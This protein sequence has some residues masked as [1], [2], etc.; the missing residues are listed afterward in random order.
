MRKNGGLS[1]RL[2][3]LAITMVA[4]LLWPLCVPAADPGGG[5]TVGDL[6]PGSE[7]TVPEEEVKD[8]FFGY[9]IGL[10]IADAY[11]SLAA[12]D[13]AHVLGEFAGK[14]SV[15][16]ELIDGV[17]RLKGESGDP[18]LISIFFLERLKTPVPYSI[19][20]YHPGSVVAD[21]TVRFY[22]YYVPR[23]SVWLS[24]QSRVTLTEVHIFAI[25]DG[26]VVVDIDA[27]IDKLLGGHLDDTWLNVL[28]LFKYEGDWHGLAAGYGPS[29]EGRSGVFNFKTN[30][31][32]FPTPDHFRTLGPYFRN[33]VRQT[34]GVEAPVPSHG[35]WPGK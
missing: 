15:P 2:G 21:S 6:L 9:M 4:G 18:N 35:N 8:R 17:E 30:N 3:L 14:T 32:L 31:I 33:F 23:K 20:G 22:E 12:E 25:Y 29:G 24:R 1:C 11:G 34:K 26:W 7:V 10:A 5:L 19:L 13:F 27:W 16:F 28:A